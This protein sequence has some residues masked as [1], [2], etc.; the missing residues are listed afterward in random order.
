MVS[1]TRDIEGL[2]HE[3][4][5][6]GD[7]SSLYTSFKWLHFDCM[8]NILCRHQRNV[9]KASETRSMFKDRLFIVMNGFITSCKKLNNV[10]TIVTNC[11]CTHWVLF[12]CL[13]IQYIHYLQFTCVKINIYYSANKKRDKH[14]AVTDGFSVGF[15]RRLLGKLLLTV[16]LITSFHHEFPY[17]MKSIYL[18][19]SVYIITM[20]Y[21]RPNQVISR[22]VA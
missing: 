1:D 11:L 18:M 19:E 2:R 4:R 17:A 13:N 21:S 16:L 12:W 5:P 20:K 10:C 3:T 6:Q 15:N 8:S 22:I 9:N 14:H 7:L